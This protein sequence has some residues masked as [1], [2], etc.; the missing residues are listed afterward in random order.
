MRGKASVILAESQYF[1]V[2]NGAVSVC[3][4]NALM[5]LCECVYKLEFCAGDLSYVLYQ[6]RI[7]GFSSLWFMS[8]G[9]LHDIPVVTII[10]H[11]FGAICRD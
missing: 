9:F 8:T 10:Y 7:E 2:Q 5:H 3:L 11:K 4:Q 1:L 6:F